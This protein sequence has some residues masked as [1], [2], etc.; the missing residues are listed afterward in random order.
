MKNFPANLSDT[1]FESI[2]NRILNGTY[3]ADQKLVISRLAKEFGVST[4][5]IREALARLNAEELVGYKA[6]QGYRV[7]ISKTTTDPT[8]SNTDAT[9]IDSTTDLP[10]PAAVKQTLEIFSDPWAFAVL[11]ELFFGVRRFDDFQKNLK[12]SRSVLTRRLKHLAKQQV[13]ERRR[14]Q[15]RPD[16]FEYRLTDRG[17]DMYPIFV[18]LKQWGEKWLDGGSTDKLRLV[19]KPCNK[20]LDVETVCAHCQKAVNAVDVSYELSQD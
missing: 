17:R 16:R 20:D 10:R 4:I 3:K 6:N 14:Y 9:E 12:I 7:A 2:K 13:I 11:E 15:T 19:H 8:L 1:A 18:S 5:P